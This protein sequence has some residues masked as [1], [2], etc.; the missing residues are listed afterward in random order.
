MGAREVGTP[1]GALLRALRERCGKTQLWVE[2]EAELA[3]GY[4]QRVES[5]KIAQPLRR[6]LERI[7]AALDARYS[8]RRDILER[9]GYIVAAPLPSAEESRWAAA[10]CE[11]ELRAVPFPAYA[12]DCATR[13]IAWNHHVPRLFG[14]AEDDRTCGR[15]A[16]AS[17]LAAWFDPASP[18]APL[19][20]EPE[21]FLPALIRALRYELEQFRAETWPTTLLAQLSDALPQFRQYWETAEREPPPASAARALVPVWLAVPDAGLLQFRLSAEPFARDARFRVVYFFPADPA[22]MRRCAA[23]AD[24]ERP[25]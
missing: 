6:T 17:L 9:F 18:L 16:G 11:R 1:G 12:L 4:V 5:G 23:W 19:V 24:E 25:E 2:A 13:L 22:T 10:V 20:A 8:E 7:L 15:L 14:V 3:S 21:T